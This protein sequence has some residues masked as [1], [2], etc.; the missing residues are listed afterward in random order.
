MIIYKV[1][2]RSY[3]RHEQLEAAIAFY[4]ELTGEKCGLRYE[5]EREGIRAAV[6]QGT[7]I[8]AGAEAGLYDHPEIRATYLV[9]RVTDF[10]DML[11]RLG[12]EI[13]EEPVRAPQGHSMIVRHPDGL[14]VEYVDGET[15]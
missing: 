4:E 3:V 6:V 8:V 2:T 14:M 7:H 13:V 1:F 5:H 10:I 9:D 15:D 11:L 12:S